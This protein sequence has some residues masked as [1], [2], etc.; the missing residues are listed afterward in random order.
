MASIL[1]TLIADGSM[2]V[3]AF[4]PSAQ[5][6]LFV[7]PHP[8]VAVVQMEDGICVVGATHGN[9]LV[10][11]AGDPMAKATLSLEEEAV[12]AIRSGTG[13]P[14]AVLF[15]YPS[16]A[17]L[18]SFAKYG[19]SCDASVVIGRGEEA[20]WRYDSP[21]VSERHARIDLVGED[22]SVTDLGS[23]N[24]TFLNGRIIP[25]NQRIALSAGDVVSVLGLTIMAGRRLLVANV[26]RGVTLGQVEG[27]V[28]IDHDAFRELC[29]PASETTG[30]LPLYYPAPRLSY[31]I[32]K[33]AFQVDEPPQPK[34]PDDKPAIMQMGPSFL[35]GIASI[36]SG[37]NAVQGIMGGGS[38]LS[39]LPS[40]AMCV[41]MLVGM[42]VWPVISRAYGKKR[43]A[44][45]ERRRQG[46]YTDYLN[47]M[48]AA[49]EE[50]CD[51]QAE[52]LRLRRPDMSLIEERV[53]SL[54]PRLMNR[55]MDHDDFMEL[56]VG[57]GDTALDADFRFPQKRF[58][59][60]DDPLLDKVS[61][62][63]ENPPV[64]R[65]V[66]L[67]FDPVRHFLAGVVGPRESVWAFVRGLMMQAASY[68]S[69]QDV[70]MVLVADSAEEREWAFARPLP[71]LFDDAGTVRYLACDYD[72]LTLVGAHL[73]HVLDQRREMRFENVGE[74]GTYYLVICANKALSERSDV[75]GDLERLHSNRGFSLVFL[76]EALSDLP[77]ECSYVIDLTEGGALQG[78]G[79]TSQ[80]S[81]A[82]SAK[83][84]ACMFDRDDVAGTM[85]RFEPD[86]LVDQAAA[87]RFSLGLARVRLDMP[88]QRSVMPSSLGFL[89]MFEV[90]NVA[91]LNIG[92]RWADD[93]ASRTLATPIGRDASGEF[94][95]LNLH[96]K[97]HGPHGLIAGTTGSGKSE[98]IITY[99]LSMCVN[100]APDQVAFVLIDYKGGGLAGA[101]DNDRIRLPHLAGTIT[102]LDGAAISRSL[103]SIKSELKRRQDAFN[104]ARDI[105]GEATMDIYKYLRYYRQGAL[106]EPLPHLFIVADEFAE[107]KQQEPEFMDELI[108]AAR[109]G[110]SLGVHLILATQKPTGVVNDQIWSNS[111]FKVCLKVSDASDS[112]EMIRRPDAAEITRP[113]RYY[114]LVGYNELFCGG[115][116][117]YAGAP[118]APTDEY[119]PRHDDTIELV[120]DTCD[121][122]DGIKPPSMA[123]KT[124]ESELNAVLDRVCQVANAQDKRAQRLWLDPLAAR[125]S[126]DDLCR[127]HGLDP[128]GDCEAVLG[129]AD[130][131]GRQ[132]QLPYVVDLAKVGNLMVYGSQGS[133]ADSLV[134]TLLFSLAER[135]SPERVSFY[136]ID[137][138]SGA[139][140]PLAELPQCGGVV[141]SGDAERLGN[142]FRMV[143][144]ECES[145]RTLLANAGCGLD[146]YNERHPQSRVGRIV[147]A[148]ANIAAF[149][150]LY[151]GYE[152]ALVTL[153][154]DA[155]RYGIHFV[156]SASSANAARMRLRANFSTSVVLML[157]DESEL[158]T[159]L[160]HRPSTTVPRQ[161]KRGYVTMGKETF[162]FQG[163]SLGPE[164][165]TDAE[166]IAALARRRRSE[167][168]GAARKIPVLPRYVHVRQMGVEP[169]GRGLVP[170]GF[171][172]LS[173]EPVFF[174]LE[175][176]PMLVLGNDVESIARYLA[177]LREALAASGVSYLVVDNAGYLGETDDPNVVQDVER[178]PE[179]LLPTLLGRDPVG[180]LVF[181]SIVE[182]V[183][184][185][186]PAAATQ[187]KEFLAKEKGK[188][189]TGLV[190]ASEMWR[191]KSL[192]DEWYKTLTAYGNGV[193]VGSGFGDQTM[194]HYAR[195]LSEYRSPAATDDGFVSMRGDV[196]GVRL[197]SASAAEDGGAAR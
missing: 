123:T 3:N 42:A 155:P 122:I 70:K 4:D 59:M 144:R 154:R 55:G 29:P 174:P 102:N 31:T 36:F 62:L 96:E 19:F 159:V 25:P 176:F 157:N 150:D 60:E 158:I 119:V 45:E 115:Q 49:F 87:M 101:F 40:I 197:L 38:V 152:D 112:K 192:Y 71:H 156:I 103:V 109:I 21:Y 1:L 137:M 191:C 118:Y 108:S 63:A 76:G 188:G 79:S 10:S 27:M 147:V 111:R 179:R 48:E 14:E 53:S 56:R 148:L 81:K 95:T 99:I 170:V 194:F 11:A 83:G 114:M 165:T 15:S 126:L 64:V 180:V 106:K 88:S 24:G 17:G 84:S 12:F 94:A 9:E 33:R 68:Y 46:R 172:K 98:F 116:S 186:P 161:D 8:G 135:Y 89:E 189:V 182:T 75:I 138:G 93:D 67:A 190:A 47:R 143:Q 51:R 72:E 117:A 23:A 134:S 73:S 142:L 146:E 100:Y 7:G 50:E 65:D 169:V 41:S 37:A 149:Y 171:G 125:I 5:S 129:E 160:G 44:E 30:E 26:P 124:D 18:R 78:L 110:R 34:K 162:E 133:G 181:T 6:V 69:Y 173:V 121:A 80:L 66:P 92:Q 141:I 113:G 120:D 127:K 20:V 105:T 195:T 85:E 104:R 39:G 187:L 140:T 136:V 90:G 57:V 22:F 132:R 177:G 54:S 163:A 107:L 183:L 145:R 184:A 167:C 28:K 2:H 43:D 166:A 128:T 139:M 168:A 185:L 13:S 97:A 151:P 74:C 164:G 58:S 77:R 91:Q 61:K 153:T 35:M 52:V 86:V 130:D 175:R 196:T 131:P 178:L 193:W 16:T 32:H 82:V